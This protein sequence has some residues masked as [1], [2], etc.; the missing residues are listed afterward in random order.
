MDDEQ[1][2]AHGSWF[3]VHRYNVGTREGDEDEKNIS[4]GLFWAN[5]IPSVF[6]SSSFLHNRSR[7][8]ERNPEPI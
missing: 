6:Q 5:A 3:I 1:Q 4:I 8:T 2:A 7:G